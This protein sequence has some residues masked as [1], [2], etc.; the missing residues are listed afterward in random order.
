MV[1]WIGRGMAMVGETSMGFW[2][3][4]HKSLF[5]ISQGPRWRAIGMRGGFGCLQGLVPMQ[6]A[7]VFNRP[8]SLQPLGQWSLRAV[9]GVSA[10]V[11]SRA[12]HCPPRLASHPAK[13]AARP[14][15]DHKQ[16]LSA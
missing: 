13:T 4:G 5:A 10:L 6:A 14:L 8:I 3:Y 12:I 9:G 7:G 11:D 2:H 16:A 1:A 15:G